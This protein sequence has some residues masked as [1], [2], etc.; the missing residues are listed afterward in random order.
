[1]ATITIN[2]A[3]AGNAQMRTLVSDALSKVQTALLLITPT[4]TYDQSAS[5]SIDVTNVKTAIQGLRRN[6][7]TVTLL[8][9]CAGQAA[10]ASGTHYY[11]SAT[12]VSTADIECEISEVG[13]SEYATATA[14]PTFNQPLGIVVSFSEA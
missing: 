7:K 14:L 5:P 4:G 11:F 9:A 8:S 6:G 2:A 3:T 12:T 10:V 1:M 13:G